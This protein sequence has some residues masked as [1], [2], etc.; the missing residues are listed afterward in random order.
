MTEVILQVYPSL[1]DEA[2]MAAQR[3]IGRNNDAYQKMLAGLI[4][5]CQAAD[6]LGYWGITHVEHH[7]HTE[8]M[9]I[10]PAPLMLN[11][12]LGHYTKRL[13][14]G[15]LGL[16]L[17]AHDPIRLAEEIAIADHMLQGRL[18]VGMAR[19][20]QARWQNILGQR[21][22]VTSTASDQSEADQRNRLLFSENFAIMKKA[23]T[24]D[25]LT[26][27]GPTYKIPYPVEG[28]PNWPP[29]ATITG[30]YG[31]PGE[32]DENGTV[33]GVGIVPKP[34]TSPHPQLFQAF[35]ASPGTLRWCGEED[36]TPTILMG[37][38]TKLRALMEIYQ[39]G[40]ASRGR[41]PRFGEGIGVCRTFYVFP[42]GTPQDEVD[43]KIRR[44]VELYEEPVWRGWYEQFGFMEGSRLDDEEGPVPK[45]GEHLADRLINS[46][47]LIGG[48]VDQVKRRIEEFLTD[49]PIDYFV[50]LFHWG[51][52]P[53]DEGLRM[54]ELFGEQIMPEFGITGAPATVAGGGA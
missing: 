46:G 7:M 22:N 13:R 54:L 25:L 23:W 34:Y 1:G 35:G 31:V 37:S 18:F 42:N 48:T 36:V 16:V 9:E 17:P 45:P 50:W 4:E 11:V 8:G 6:D 33:K 38:M 53:R 15:Q 14:H 40:A 52:I 27:D 47:L 5:V 49:L 24:E 10:S 26:Y 30:K 29:A 2:A 28:I 44:S 3:P 21:F 19:G 41:H 20:Y 39:E 51:M 32:V 12:H 43:A